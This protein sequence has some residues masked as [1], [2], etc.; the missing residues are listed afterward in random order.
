MKYLLI[1][2][3]SLAANIYAADDVFYR[4][5]D[6]NG[7]TVINNSIPVD[8]T[9]D[10]Y[11]VISSKGRVIRTVERQL[12]AD[13]LA[14]RSDEMIAE[15]KRKDN[16]LKQDEFDLELLRKYSFVSDIEAEKERKIREMTVSATILKGNLYGVRSELEIEYDR[17]AAAEKKG[18]K[19]SKS[20]S[21]RIETLEAKI[22]TTEELLKKREADIEKT[23]KSYLYSIERFKELLALRK[24]QQ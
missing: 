23:R 4:Y 16:K 8:K 13:E 24:G 10:G 22:T 19:V 2:T 14:K 12:T 21:E 3:L 6:E 18:K 7:S 15:Q 20:L 11:D 9:G 17:A 5:V 1:L